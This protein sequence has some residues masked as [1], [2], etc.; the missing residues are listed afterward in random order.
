MDVNMSS[1]STRLAFDLD[2]WLVD[3]CPFVVDLLAIDNLEETA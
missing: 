1:I 2:S 3:S